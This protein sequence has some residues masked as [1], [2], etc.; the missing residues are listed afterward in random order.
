MNGYGKNEDIET[1]GSK[2]KGEKKKG[3]YWYRRF[4]RGETIS[5]KDN[6]EPSVAASLRDLSIQA[7][8]CIVSI[9]LV[10]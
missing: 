7:R 6:V 8:C 2:N 9:R 4:L 3:G 5:R 1:R 10:G